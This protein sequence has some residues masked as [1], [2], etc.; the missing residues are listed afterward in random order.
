MASVKEMVMEL[1]QELPDDVSIDDLMYHLYAK[2][3]ILKSKHQI[4]LGNIRTH[5]EVEAL[6]KTW[7]Q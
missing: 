5:E 1:I 6:S 2:Q 4:A 7:H 3:K